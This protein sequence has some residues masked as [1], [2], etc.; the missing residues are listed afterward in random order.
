MPVDS[1]AGFMNK[2][3]TDQQLKE[4]EQWRYQTFSCPRCGYVIPAIQWHLARF[5]CWCPRCQR[6]LLNKFTLDREVSGDARQNT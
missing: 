1:G 6:V 2:K 4:L 5:D 3:I